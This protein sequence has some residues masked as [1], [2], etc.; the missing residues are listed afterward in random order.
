MRRFATLLGVFALSVGGAVAIGG[1]GGADPGGQNGSAGWQ[2]SLDIGATALPGASATSVALSDFSDC[3][4][5]AGLDIGLESG[6]DVDR[7]A[8]SVTN[9]AGDTLLSFEQNSGPA[10]FSGVFEGYKLLQPV[11]EPA[12]RLADRVVRVGRAEQRGPG[13]ASGSGDLGRVVRA[14]PVQRRRARHRR[15]RLVLRRHR[16]VPVDGAGSA[17][18]RDAR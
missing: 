13:V 18:R 1:A 2:I 17:G 4:S 12:H 8:G 3:T 11:V 14:L 6:P 10:N 9:E 16:H 5:P 7:E 15:A